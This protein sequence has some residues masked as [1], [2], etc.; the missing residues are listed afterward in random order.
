MFFSRPI[1]LNVTDLDTGNNALLK[2][3]IMDSFAREH[4]I[5][6]STT[7]T[8]RLTKKVDY[9]VIKVFN[10]SVMVSGIKLI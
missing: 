10:F 8:I 4:F 1:T 5:I 9:E 7:G 3:T 6:E 2:F